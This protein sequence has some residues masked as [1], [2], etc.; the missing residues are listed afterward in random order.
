MGNASFNEY[1]IP[2]NIDGEILIPYVNLR[3]NGRRFF[4]G[5]GLFLLSILYI[6]YL[7]GLSGVTKISVMLL[8][9]TIFLTFGTIGINNDPISIFIVS[10]IR[11][12]KRKDVM[13]YNPKVKLDLED[14]GIELEVRKTESYLYKS[15]LNTNSKVKSGEITI[16]PELLV[17]DEE[18]KDIVF[19]EDVKKLMKKK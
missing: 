10:F 5:L 8:Y 6:N 1:Y 3:V 9:G 2:V 7:S 14:V 11:F 17:N 19:I 12:L 4:E 16:L 13:L 18:I 15:F